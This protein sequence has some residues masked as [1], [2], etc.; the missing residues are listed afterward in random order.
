MTKHLVI[1]VDPGKDGGVA[2]VDTRTRNYVVHD[3]PMLGTRIK[4]KGAKVRNKR[5]Y[6]I[7]GLVAIFQPIMHQVRAAAVEEV[8]AMPKQGVTSMF[9][10]GAGWGLVYGMLAMAGLPILRPTPQAWKGLILAGRGRDKAASC[11]VAQELF[12]GAPVKG[13]QGGLLDGRAEALLIAEWAAR[14]S[15]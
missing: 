4:G 13:P 11:L 8:H 1:G 6:D 5:V 2:V 12:P 15:A 9:S 7:A 10:M 3:M 14:T